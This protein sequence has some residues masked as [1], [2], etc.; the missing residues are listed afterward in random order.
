MLLH[1]TASRN[2]DNYTAVWIIAAAYIVACSKEHADYTHFCFRAS[3]ESNL[4]WIN[5]SIT[6]FPSLTWF[7]IDF[8]VKEALRPILCSHGSRNPWHCTTLKRT[9]VPQNWNNSQRSSRSTLALSFAASW[10]SAQTRDPSHQKEG[11]A[12]AGN[13]HATKLPKTQISSDCK[14][15]FL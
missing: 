14:E 1:S 7:S 8:Y 13:T 5:G 15:A 3:S 6:M 9:E 12:K 11:S 2:R 4:F 10:K